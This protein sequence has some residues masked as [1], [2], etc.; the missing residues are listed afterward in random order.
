MILSRSSAQACRPLAHSYNA[1]THT[2]AWGTDYG[3]AGSAIKP[4]NLSA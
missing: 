3:P 2:V 1:H 4:I